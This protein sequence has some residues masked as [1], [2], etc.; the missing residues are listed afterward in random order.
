MMNVTIEWPHFVLPTM[1]MLLELQASIG[2]RG[3]L[4]HLSR[5]QKAGT[6]A[7]II[8]RP[9]YAGY[10]IITTIHRDNQINCVQDLVVVLMDNLPE[11]HQASTAGFSSL[12]WLCSEF[13]PI[14]FSIRI[15]A[16]A[17]TRLTNWLIAPST[18]KST[19]EISKQPFLMGRPILLDHS[20]SRLAHTPSIVSYSCQMETHSSHSCFNPEAL[21][22]P[23]SLP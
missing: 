15:T 14:R 3:A 4:V 9:I 6:L 13:T 22:F 19:R 20:V 23:L 1:G 7:W 21:S 11:D 8:N 5:T 2:I 17:R 18:S 16:I 10:K 12:S